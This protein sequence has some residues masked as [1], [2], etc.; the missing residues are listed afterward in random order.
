[1]IFLRN[2]YIN[3]IK[4]YLPNKNAIILVG[5]RQVWKSSL[6]KSLI[7]EKMIDNEVLLN[8]DDFILEEFSAKE[9]L[10]FLEFKYDIKNKKYLIID[11]AQKIKNIGIIIKYLVDKN[12]ES[13]WNWRVVI[14]CTR[15]SVKSIL[16][17]AGKKPVIL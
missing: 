3:K 2:S 9:F 12:K 7:Q 8:W 6:I 17:M 4:K 10:E 15:D 13:G 16:R 14:L 5:A 1:M 11:E